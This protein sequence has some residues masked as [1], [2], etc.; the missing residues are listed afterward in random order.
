MNQLKSLLRPALVLG[1]SVLAAGA[2]AQ[3]PQFG[4]SLP[5]SLR[6]PSGPP[7]AA[8]QALREQAMQ[9]LRRQFEQADL[10]ANG[11]LTK[12]EADRAG[13]GYVSARFEQI[14]R[15]KRGAVSFDEVR[16][17]LPTRVAK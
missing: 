1:L 6:T 7:P 5:P 14:D 11:R 2:A 3:T 15:G 13:L 16:E 4:P 9:K 10:D 12:V 8:G 17:A